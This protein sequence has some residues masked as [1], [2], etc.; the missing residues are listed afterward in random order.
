MSPLRVLSFVC[1]V[2]CAGTAC[3][4]PEAGRGKREE[5]RVTTEGGIQLAYVALG[6][7]PDTVVVLHGGPGVDHAYLEAPL[8][9]LLPGR[10]LIFYDQ[11]GRGRSDAVLDSLALAPDSDVADLESVRRHFGLSRLTLI[12]HHWGAAVSALYAVRHPERVSR[13]LMVSPFV[14]HPSFAFEIGMEHTDTTGR[15]R[16]AR[17]LGELRRGEHVTEACQVV[18]PTFFYGTLPDP[19][20][21]TRTVGASVCRAPADRIGQVERINYAVLSK[22]GYWSWREALHGVPVPVLVIEGSGNDMV[23]AAATRWAQHLPNARVL[24]VPGAFGFPWLGA[25]AAIDT[26]MVAF[27]RG[28]WPAGATKPE[29][30]VTQV[31]AAA[32]SQP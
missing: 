32:A 8:Q 5:G 20:A 6:S 17:L 23:D 21:D 18:W 24:F 14:V 9:A 3:R 10:T 11:R 19:H 12:G 26:A 28:N 15:G 29:P 4:A 2:V 13:I 31:S 27:L 22:L 7:G 16:D 30:F 1:A 25:T